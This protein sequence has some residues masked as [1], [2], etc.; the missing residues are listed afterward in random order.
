MWHST[1]SRAL[2]MRQYIILVHYLTTLHRERAAY[3]PVVYEKA[4]AM[5]L[6]AA[7]MDDK[8]YRDT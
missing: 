1:L 7:L 5:M 8:Y 4:E 3:E 2:S 6:Q